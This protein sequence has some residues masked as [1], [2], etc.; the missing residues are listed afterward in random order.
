MRQKPTFPQQLVDAIARGNAIVVV[1]AGASVA[2]GLPTWAELLKLLILECKKQTPNFEDEDELLRLLKGGH[3]ID[4]A[5][6]CKKAL[7]ESAY[8]DFIQ[9]TFRP[10]NRKRSQLHKA[11]LDIPFSAA[12]TTNYDTLLEREHQSIYSQSEGVPIYT[13]RNTAHLAQLTASRSFYILKIHGHVD[14][15]ESVILSR[16]DYHRLIHNNPA[17]KSTISNIIGSKTLVF[18]GYSLND[19]DLNL[20]LSEHVTMF[21]GFSSRHFAFLAKPGKVLSSSLADNFNITAISY[22]PADNHAA[23]KRILKDLLS[24]V[25]NAQDSLDIEDIRNRS[26]KVPAMQKVRE[27]MRYESRICTYLN[28]HI[29]LERARF[30]QL[31]SH[32]A[33]FTTGEKDL[34]SKS[35]EF[36]ETQK[37]EM[38]ALQAELSRSHRM[39]AI[40]TLAGGIAHDFRNILTVITANNELSIASSGVPTHVISNLKQ[41]RI[42]SERAQALIR[43]ILAFS[44]GGETEKKSFDIVDAIS[45]SVAFLRST[46]PA[47]AIIKWAP[48]LQSFTINADRSQI[49]QVIL[50]LGI[51]AAQSLKDATGEIVVAV[52]SLEKSASGIERIAKL[53][54][55][56]YVCMTIKDSG[57]GISPQDIL[58]IFDP[59]FTTK[60]AGTGL[61]LSVVHGVVESHGGSIEV[62][63]KLGAGTTFE[64]IL[65][66]YVGSLPK[67]QN[68]P[69][70][71]SAAT[72]KVIAL[73]DDEPS[74]LSVT[75]LVLKSSGHKVIEFEDA[76]AAVRYIL[77]KNTRLD[78]IIT[79][80]VMPKFSG[81]DIAKSVRKARLGIPVIICSGYSL[82]IDKTKR[83]GAFAIIEK[84]FRPVEFMAVVNSALAPKFSKR[85]PVPLRGRAEKR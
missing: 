69:R 71:E 65:P 67:P 8:R 64:V 79:D 68:P 4:V 17:F 19:P 85:R 23:L 50:N 3:L 25:L 59:F 18:I 21:R 43:Q 1:G 10:A 81:L 70:T 40:G 12:I 47:S 28:T 20:L 52:N 62:F 16:G 63:S 34:I 55:G 22:D 73:I 61:G 27:I 24:A 7:N 14:D 57:C 11:I 60:A 6:A 72:S 38:A 26:A 33:S 30:L 84:P 51:N 32:T 39:E 53:P 41:I 76:E 74:I 56:R 46:I 75:S 54:P 82:D 83:A 5:D 58:R 66:S 2:H 42:A 9:K 44:R 13:H 48:P 45:E 80:Q 15:I 37:R 77:D 36:G 31:Q 78:L 29:E 49:Q 35:I